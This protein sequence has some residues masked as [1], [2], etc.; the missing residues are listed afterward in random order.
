MPMSIYPASPAR[1]WTVSRFRAADTTGS[2]DAIPSILTLRGRVSVGYLL[3]TP[4]KPGECIYVPDREL[5]PGW[6]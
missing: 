2:S 3:D 5:L 1:W 4:V 6:C